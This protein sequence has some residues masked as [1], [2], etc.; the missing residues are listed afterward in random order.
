MI[1]V[2]KMSRTALLSYGKTFSHVIECVSAF[3]VITPTSD[4]SPIKLT[5]W[6]LLKIPDSIQ[7][8]PLNYVFFIKA[9][10]HFF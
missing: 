7:Y 9:N 3:L 1:P 10:M 5:D 4:K 6:N 2:S 8:F